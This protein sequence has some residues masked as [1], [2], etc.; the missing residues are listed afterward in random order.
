MTICKV[1]H[2]RDDV[3][4][5]Y[6]SRKGG[7]ELT[8]TEDSVDTSTWCVEDYIKKAKKTNCSYQKKHEPHK[9]QNKNNGKKKQGH[10]YFKQQT[11]EISHE[12]SWTW[13]R[14]GNLQRETEL[15]T[16]P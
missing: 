2:A 8:S 5:V 4:N 14:K 3:D 1:L 13:L 12:K 7:R 9:N 16:M 10:G 6:V 15:K 11:N